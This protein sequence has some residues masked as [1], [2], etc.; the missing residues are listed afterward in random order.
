MLNEER[1]LCDHIDRCIISEDEM[2]DGA[3]PLLRD[4]RRKISQQQE[5]ARARI[6]GMIASS[7][8]RGMLQDDIVTM[9]DGRFVIP[10]Q[11]GAQSAF[12]RNRA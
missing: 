8:N 3:S 4:I 7:S 12:S 9:R 11:A 5:A 6:H 1:P 10:R 2:A